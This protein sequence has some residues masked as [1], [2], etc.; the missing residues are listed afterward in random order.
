MLIKNNSHYHRNDE[1]KPAKHDL[2]FESINANVNS[3]V[4]THNES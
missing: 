4:E 3:S 1:S 2:T